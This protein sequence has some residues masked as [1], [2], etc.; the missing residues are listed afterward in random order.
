MLVNLPNGKTVSMSIEAY[1][2]LDDEEIKYMVSMNCGSVASSPWCA[3]A[4]KKPGKV[5]VKDEDD[6]PELTKGMTEEE[7]ELDD[8]TEFDPLET[9]VNTDTEEYPEIE[10]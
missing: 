6:D 2:A 5:R 3:S 8:D 10:D 7:K 1:L 9:D 4:V